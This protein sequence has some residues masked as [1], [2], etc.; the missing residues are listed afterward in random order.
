MLRHLRQTTSYIQIICKLLLLCMLML[1]GVGMNSVYAQKKDK[2]TNIKVKDFVP[3]DTFS[4]LKPNKL[5]FKNINSIQYYKNP[6]ELAKIKKLHKNEK[7]D[8]LY[9]ILFK[10]VEN[11]GIDNFKHDMSLIWML[12]RVAESKG[13]F[14]TAK[15]LW[16]IIIKHY[17][18]DLQQTLLHYDSLTRFEKDMY[19]ELD[20]YYELVEMRKAIDTLHPPKGVHLNMG[21]Q[22]NSP[23]EEY[24]LTISGNDST[25]LFTSKRNRNPGK[26]KHFA[27][28]LNEDIYIS[29]KKNGDWVQAIPFDKINTK[30]NEGSPYI[31]NDGKRIVF[32]RCYSPDGLGNCDIFYTEKINDS[33]W[34]NAVNLGPNI[35][36]YAWDS[37]PSFSATGD[38]IYFASD[39][40]GGFGGVD[41]YYSTKLP[42]G[43]WSKSLNIGP[44]INTQ[45]NEVSPYPHP[46]YDILYFSS[47]GHMVNFGQ[48]D[49]FKCYNVRG[50]WTEPK[51]VGP[52]V[53]G[54]GSEFYFTIDSKS[55]HLFY[56][57]SE[58]G[59]LENLDLHSFPLPMEAQPNAIVRFTGK[60]TEK[61]TGE[62]FS[63]IVSVLDMDEGIE[64][65]PKYL[66]E[67]GTFEFDLM[68]DKEYL[69]IVQGD[70]FFRFEELFTLNGDK[71]IEVKTQKIENKITFKSIDFDSNSAKL[72]PEMENNLHLIIDFLVT[73]PNLL[74]E[75]SGH[76]DA[77]G[78][79]ENNTYLS[80]KRADV[81][82]DY[83][84]SYGSLDPSRVTAIGWG[85]MKP[86]IHPEITQEHKQMNRRVE[87]KLIPKD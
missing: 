37:H 52:L 28:I 27:P 16:R 57:K 13:D 63:G 31:S 10:Y 67:D 85:S 32:T 56:A 48:Y 49:I 68:N 42:N 45:R 29:E 19:V 33:T 1:F 21:D 69:L 7:W 75:I 46:K 58:V 23:Y 6:S 74:L 86:L 41:I 39:R 51:N 50:E 17:R 36:S 24:G 14:D 60:V 8:E 80:Q 11:F 79:A 25:V 73:H 4:I 78:N 3:S 87:F 65:A 38:T 40:R 43:T 84:I 66:R 15:H 82:R 72:K 22:I 71:N 54:E 59:D 30:Y 9:T 2:N 77:V 83:I 47:D 35:N 61:Q 64:I 20:Y 5:Q 12:A 18:G 26:D 81:I 62:V 53:N 34:T 70:N 44:I 55:Q 76:T